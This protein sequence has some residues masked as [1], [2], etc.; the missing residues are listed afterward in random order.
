MSEKKGFNWWIPIIVVIVIITICRHWFETGHALALCRKRMQQRT[1][2][3][4][5]ADAGIGACN[6]VVHSEI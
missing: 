1:T 2:D 5:L 3:Q 6:E 4:R